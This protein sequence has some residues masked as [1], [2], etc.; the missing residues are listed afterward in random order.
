MTGSS[1]GERTNITR[2]VVQMLSH[3]T[4]FS[5]VLHVQYYVTIQ[6]LWMKIYQVKRFS[7]LISKERR[8]S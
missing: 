8:V 4:G 6:K 5:L 7:S 1:Y 3:L 2:V